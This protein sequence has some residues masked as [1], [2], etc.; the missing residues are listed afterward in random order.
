MDRNLYPEHINKWL[1]IIDECAETDPQRMAEHCD[2]VERYAGE[3]RNDAL[4]G[5]SIFQRGYSAYAQ[6]RLTDSSDYLSSALT[7]L[8]SGGEYEMGARV[9]TAL[10]NIADTQGDTSLATDCYFKGLTLCQEH[11]LG[12]GEFSIR[13]NIASIFL[14]LEEFAHA[15]EMLRGCEELTNGGLDVAHSAKNVMWANLSECCLHLGELEKSE[16]YLEQLKTTYKDEFTP[17][18]R[19][20]VA[21]LEAKFYFATNNIPACEK[22]IADLDAIEFNSMLVLNAFSELCQHAELLL[23][24]GK[25]TDFFSMIE[26]IAQYAKSPKAEAR[27]LDLRLKQC[28]KSGDSRGYAEM[29]IRHYELTS[30]MSSER[31]KIISHNIL[32]R[33]RLEE[34]ETRRREIEMTNLML[35]QKSEHDPLTGLNNRYK[36]NE[37]AETAFQ[38]AYMEGTPLTIEIL[39]IDCFKE[40]NDNYGHQAGDDCLVRIAE[41]IRSLEVY[42]GVHTARYGGDEFVIIYENHSLESVTKLASHLQDKLRRMNIEHKFS[43]VCDRVTISQGLFRRI[44]KGGNKLWDFLSN[45]DMALYGVK[46]RSKNNF[47]VGTEFKEVRAYYNESR[48]S[49]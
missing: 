18:D 19:L 43:K 9:Y 45:A 6:G 22:A 25:D 31:N 33:I 10:G 5:Y 1:S 47:Y 7:Y 17:M 27:L 24:R 39:D 8:L 48:K 3:T 29:A 41:L 30:L 15:A 36:L 32:N 46:A 12:R 40:Y 26:R 42:P 16:A 28:K 23:Q 11:N 14:S 20:M 35:R 37:L 34:E 21:M 44:P 13:S 49:K 2:L 4:M 38:K